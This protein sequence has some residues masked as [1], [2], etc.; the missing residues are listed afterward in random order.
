MHNL[1]LP[2]FTHSNC[3]AYGNGNDWKLEW[4]N[5]PKKE[6]YNCPSPPCT[7]SL[8][9]KTNYLHKLNETHQA[10]N[11]RFQELACAWHFMHTISMNG[12][13]TEAQ[14]AYSSETETVSLS[15]HVWLCNPMNCSLPGSSVHGIFQASILVWI[16]IPFSRASSW[17]GIKLGSPTLQADSLTSEPPGKPV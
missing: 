3:G 10:H 2:T 6:K 14:L 8:L 17:P 9:W 7:V 12:T 1:K 15:V 16:A 13:E 5:S 4:L 11:S